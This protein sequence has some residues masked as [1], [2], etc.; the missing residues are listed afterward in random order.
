[1]ASVAPIST[2][3]AEEQR[4]REWL[5]LQE[6]VVPILGDLNRTIGERIQRRTPLE[7]RWLRDLRQ[8][9]GIYEPEIAAVLREEKERSS[10]FINITRPK[11][12]AWRARLIDML[13]PNDERN[14]GIDPTPVPTLTQSA[15]QA[16][17]E[18]EQREGQVA[19][20]LEQ[21][22]AAVDAGEPGYPDEVATATGMAAEA[23]E[24][25]GLAQQAQA[26]IEEARRRCDAMQREID[27]QL[28][29][30]RFPTVCRDVIDDMCKV[31]SGV[32]KG[33]VVS[34]RAR[35][36]WR[37]DPQTGVAAL[38]ADDTPQPSA[39]RV[40]FWH[41]FPDPD[42]A[43]VEEGQGTFERHLPNR[44]MLRRMARDLDFSPH[45]VREML[46]EGPRLGGADTMHWMSELRDMESSAGM[47]G[48]MATL[49]DR[50]CVWEYH[51]PLEVE[52][53]AMLI[54]AT[55]RHEDAERFE[56]EADPLDET[57][58]RLF[59]CDERLLKIEEDYLLD[60][61]ASLYSVASFEKAEA[62]IMGGI[63]VPAIMRHEQ[64]MLNSAVRM[65]MDN[66]ALATGPQIVVNKA[67]I[68]PESGGWKLTPRKVW[69]IVRSSMMGESEKIVPFSTY[70]I[71]INQEMIANIVALATRFVDEAV[72]MPLLAQGEQ[73]Q[74]ATKTAQGMSMLFNSASVVFRR[75]VKNWDD[76]ITTPLIQR[77]FDFNM[78]FS[79]KDEIKGDMK[80]EARGTSVLL[81]REMQADRMMAILAQWSTHPILGVGLRAYNCMRLVLQAMN[82]N[83]DDVLSSEEEY[84]QKLQQMSAP[85]E[86][87]EAQG[88]DPS[89][90]IR[91][92]VQL[93]TAEID[94]KS[95]ES[96]A[97]V[98]Y[99]IAQLNQ[100]TEFAQLAQS[101][102][103]SLAQVEAMFRGKELDAHVKLAGDKLR[104]DSAERK[105][106]AEISAE[107][108]NAR[109][110][111]A[112][113]REPTG[114]GGYIS[115]GS[116]RP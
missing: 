69:N 54:R 90:Q 58:V 92:E 15:R 72:A 3:A 26:E 50:W 100:Q 93:R 35:Q 73:G 78:Q 106:A 107:R 66:A 91:A 48:E 81:V 11:T 57:M 99:A 112:E 88:E 49:R 47:A 62:S 40:D 13:L 116:P 113:G 60:S 6:A 46:R 19:A 103:I 45:A 34:G 74:T 17:R 79:P 101:R 7:T 14:W 115:M 111:R 44:K 80:V 61:G 94:A 36:L 20:T 97:Q 16:L 87:G 63:G 104:A 51:G 18:A 38:E 108:Q 77:F 76:D 110:A 23:V 53:V 105:I 82:I 52:Q 95:R 43:T 55:G 33:P 64:S 109:E 41:F 2:G 114:S 39:R 84:L 29:E 22:N 56:A 5:R 31:G 1:M 4:K 96:V 71:P 59:F 42:A 98:N 30:C 12:N 68:E 24:L 10:V 70:N 65:M 102:D 37:I 83:P 9:H 27:D 86:G 28:V 75:V 67:V 85:E 21:H 89:A 32:I 25:R 8:Y